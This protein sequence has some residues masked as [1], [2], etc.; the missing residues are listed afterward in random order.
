M[1]GTV[2]KVVVAL[3]VSGIP[4]LAEAYFRLFVLHDLCSHLFLST[5]LGSFLFVGNYLDILDYSW[6]TVPVVLPLFLD[7]EGMSLDK[8]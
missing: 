7:P 1:V 4:C 5:I 8:N 6:A 2:H 3:E